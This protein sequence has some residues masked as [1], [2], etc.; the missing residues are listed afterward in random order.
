MPTNSNWYSPDRT[1][2]LIT[3]KDP[4][5]WDDFHRVAQEAHLQI[6]SVEHKVD[7]LI[8]TPPELPPGNALGHFRSIF[9]HQPKNVNRVVIINGGT[10]SGVMFIQQLMEIIAKLFPNK[11]KVLVVRS[12]DEARRRLELPERTTIY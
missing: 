9:S 10:P 2:V 12:I 4:L 3:L 5:T 8:E 1:C 7:L 11:Q 6:R